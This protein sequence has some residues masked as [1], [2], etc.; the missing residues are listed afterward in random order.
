[1][2]LVGWLFF[3]IIIFCIY[4][5][6]GLYISRD[7]TQTTTYILTW[8][9]Y[10]CLCL[11]LL[12]IVIISYFWETVRNK[13]GP[14]GIRGPSGETGDQGPEGSC[15][16]SATQSYLIMSLS[17]FID[18]LY[19]TRTGKSILNPET[20]QFISKYMTNKI[21]TQ[22][23][24]R[25]YSVIV[26][27]LSNQNKPVED[28]VNYIKSIWKVWFDLIYNANPEW[29]EDPTGDEDYSWGGENPFTEIRKYDIY[30]WGITRT[31]RPLKAEI[32]RTNPEYQSA[33]L[34]MV[35]TIPRL[36]ILE[37][38]DYEYRG[39]DY[40]TGVQPDAGWWRPKV[41][42]LGADKYYPVGDIITAGNKRSVYAMH[43]GKVKIGDMVMDSPSM[44]RT[45]YRRGN[46]PE[47]RSVIVAGDVV[48]PTGFEPKMYIGGNQRLIIGTPKCP[49]GY[50]DMGDVLYQGSYTN[51]NNIK[52]VPEE[53]VE[54]N[55]RDDTFFV[56]WPWG[57]N[58]R[59]NVQNTW[60]RENKAATGDNGYNLMRGN[61]RRPLKRI[62]AECL[63]STRIPQ[64]KAP[65]AEYDALGVGWYGHPYKLD[66]RYSIFTFLEMVPEGLIVHKGTGRR[67]YIIH[68]GGEE[69]NIY[70]VLE[71]NDEV[72]KFESALQVNSDGVKPDQVNIR[73]ISRKDPRQ[74]WNIILD[75]ND[76]RFLKLK[77]VQNSKYLYVGLQPITGAAQFSTVDLDFNN[78]TTNP[79]FGNLSADQAAANTTF[80]FISAFGTQM[81][82]IDNSTPSAVNHVSG[83]RVR[84]S[85]TAGQQLFLFGVFIYGS[86]GAVLNTI[87]TTT[88]TTATT[89][90]TG[91]RSSSIYQG[92]VASNALKVV[93]EN[94]ARNINNAI[95]ME[96]LKSQ[97]D[98]LWNSWDTNGIYSAATNND[99]TAS[100]GGDWWEYV[101]AEPVNI[102]AVEIWGRIDNTLTFRNML[103]EIFDD[104]RFASENTSDPVWNANTGSEII[105]PAYQ[106]FI[107]SRNGIIRHKDS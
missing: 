69:A 10:S 26:A 49:A 63:R 35:D 4:V 104:T 103:I 38:N 66:P 27:N 102:A 33:K 90:G 47:M 14:G 37:S 84:I 61:N 7:I 16:I 11:T 20:Q 28:L 51:G 13:T 24:S 95:N 65:E 92:H 41:Q 74:Q 39:D 107:I 86:N 45:F 106:A 91:A 8:V 98:L 105:N 1:M 73:P 5:L 15:S 80:T 44:R 17:Q 31:F 87:G 67:F 60:N 22:A 82:I 94:P 55:A 99:G 78:Y 36:K 76:K 6:A 29:F 100:T 96:P 50:T 57:R 2:W 81:D 9:I 62:K 34:P 32:C 85:S 77:N 30:Y 53:C 56:P 54:N 12:T 58:S 3:G 52:C 48:D 40:K 23:G 43:K 89:S 19:R 64:T 97:P 70:N 83:N 93:G 25:Q 46:G 68:Y 79:A 75:T 88:T 72:N 71:Y 101:F 59:V 18:E 21:A 42:D